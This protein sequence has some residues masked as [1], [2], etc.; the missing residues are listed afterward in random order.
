MRAPP[1]KGTQRLPDLLELPELM[2]NKELVHVDASF[3]P[4]V[5]K[6]LANRQADL[7]VLDAA[8][9]SGDFETL[10]TLSHKI[11]GAG[12]SYGFDRVSEI[13][14]TIERAAKAGDAPTVGSELERLRTHLEQVEVVYE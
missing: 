13:A 6:F 4:L 5:P 10:W 1:V 3:E 2:M 8:L 11:K 14:A 9:A 7:Q 12:G